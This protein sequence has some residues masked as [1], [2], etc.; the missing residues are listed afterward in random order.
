MKIIQ[1]FW[2]KPMVCGLGSSHS[3]RFVGGWLEEKYHL[4]SW[5]FSCMQ[6][7]QYYPRIELI[8]D[9]LGYEILIKELEL[10]YDNVQIKLDL[11]N[12]YPP[13]LWALGKIYSYSIQNE[14]FIHVDSDVYIW[15]LFSTRIHNARLIA[16]NIEIHYPF[17]QSLFN[18]LLENEFY[19]PD[20]VLKINE[21]EKSVSAFNA[22]IIGGNDY[23]FFKKFT[24]EAIRFVDKNLQKLHTIDIG[25]FNTIF[26]QHL[27]YC[28]SKT[29]NISVEC[30]TNKTYEEELGKQL[31]GLNRLLEAP[32][33]AKFIHLYGEDCKKNMAYC[34]E[35]LDRVVVHYPEF[36]YNLEK[37]LKKKALV[38]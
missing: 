6:L 5:I 7:K 1:S 36:Y 22:G 28:L 2:T 15:D 25:R 29:N 19:I 30:F 18:N 27:F 11:L 4:A 3:G 34:E 9:K 21:R 12:D 37:Y 14:P 31:K 33:D 10:P 23:V 32:D 17:Y 20:D 26:E 35:V 38:T 16:Q 8:T 24:K 13:G